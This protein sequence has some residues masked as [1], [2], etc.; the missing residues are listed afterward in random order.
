MLA[1]RIGSKNLLIV[2]ILVLIF[3]LVGSGTLY[4][5][6]TQLPAEKGYKAAKV[7]YNRFMANPG[8]WGQ[9]HR[10]EAL[11]KDFD[12]LARNYPRSKRADDALYLAAG[13]YSSLYNYSGWSSDLQQSAKRYKMLLKSYS[14]SRLADDALYNLG[15]IALKLK[16]KKKDEG[17]EK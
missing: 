2:F 14:Q 15:A 12:G 9:R 13:L 7:R 16:D 3:G 1:Y 10:W 5:A 8:K 6:G 4:G 11:I 17:K